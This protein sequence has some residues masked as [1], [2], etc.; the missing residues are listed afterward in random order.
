MLIFDRCCLYYLD[1]SCKLIFERRLNTVTEVDRSDSRPRHV[2]FGYFNKDDYLDIA[3]ANSESDNIGIFL[4]YGNGSFADQLTYSTGFQTRPY[5]VSIG[6]FNND[7]HVDLV[8]ANYGTNSIGVLFGYSDGTFATPILTKIG[9]SRPQSL[10]V[11]DINHDNRMDIVVVSNGTLDIMVLLGFNNGSFRIGSIY[12]MGYD[13]FPYAIASAD[14]NKDN[15]MDIAVINY[16]IDNLVILL[17]D[18]YG[19]WTRYE[20]STGIG[21]QPSSLVLG[22]VNN[23]DILDIVVAN[24]GRE[25]IGIF[26]GYQNGTFRDSI[27]HP[28]GKSSRPWFI[29]LGDFENDF[30][31]DIAVIDILNNHLIIFKGNGNESFSIELKHNTGLNSNPYSIA[32]DDFHP[33]NKSDIVIS[34]YENNN[35]LLL[36]LYQI[37]PIAI[38]RFYSTGDDSLPFY[39]VVDDFNN[40]QQLDIIVSDNAGKRLGMFLGF[41]NGT[42]SQFQTVM[43][44]EEMSPLFIISADLNNDHQ[45]DIIMTIDDYGVIGVVLG[46]NDGSFTFSDWYLTPKYSIT[47]GIT[48]ADVNNDQNI[49]II[50]SHMWSGYIGIFIGYGNGSLSQVNEYSTGPESYPSSLVAVD[51]NNDHFVDLAVIS[52]GEYR[53]SIHLGFGNGSFI[54]SSIISTGEHDP[55]QITA[56]DL[57]NDDQFDLVFISSLGITILFGYGN[58]T[59]SNLQTYHTN[60]DSQPRSLIINDFNQDNRLDI[61]VSIIGDIKLGIFLGYGDGR[62]TQMQSMSTEGDGFSRSIVS[63]DFNNDKQ[64]D[65]VVLGIQP[66]GILVYLTDLIALFEKEKYYL[67]GSIAHPYSITSGYFN[68]DTQL[69]IV[70]MDSE[71]ANGDVFVQSNNGR[72]IRKTSFST[73]FNSNPRSV[74]CADFNKDNRLDIATA[75]YRNSSIT[76]FTGLGDGTFNELH[77]Y[78]T[79]V[80]S[81]PSSAS[82]GDLNDDSWVDMIVTNQEKDNIGV[83]LTFNYRTFFSF[84]IQFES[85][86]FP[87]SMATADLNNDSHMDIVVSIWDPESIIIYFGDGKG[88]FMKAITL[89]ADQYSNSIAV[90]DFNGDNYLDIAV[91]SWSEFGLSIFL[92]HGNGT[93]AE[94]IIYFI[95]TSLSIALVS[96]DLNNDTFLDLV[97][98]DQY[99][100]RIGV[101]LGYGNGSFTQIK[102]YFMSNGSVSTSMVIEDLNGDNIRDIVIAN[103]DRHCLEILL[104]YGNGSFTDATCFSTGRYSGPCSIALGDFN[105]DHFIDIAVANQQAHNIQIFLGYG[106]GS[107]SKVRTYS[108]GLQSILRSITVGD[109]NNDS[110]LDLIFTDDENE[111]SFIGIL[112]GND[113]ELFLV[114]KMYPIGLNTRPVFILINDLNH[115]HQLDIL[116]LNGRTETIRVMLNDQSESFGSVM[117]FS[118]GD[119]SQPISSA[120][121]HLDDDHQIDIAVANYGTSNI[122]IFFGYEKG[123]FRRE[124]T[125]ST[126]TDSYPTSIALVDFNHDNHTDIVVTNRGTDNICILQGYSN[127][128]FTLFRTYSTGKGSSPSFVAIA[129]LNKDS[130]VDLVIANW[131]IN[132]F[133]IFFGLDY[134]NFSSPIF[135]PLGYNARPASI[136]IGHFNNDD[137][138]D[139]ALANYGSH[140]MQIFFQTY[141]CH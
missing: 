114:P 33:D 107:F 49:D 10:A 108:T 31:V 23:D 120:L 26:Y 45:S 41:G 140:E 99:D 103:R 51:L 55:I 17:S 131:G 125:Y 94:R 3:V 9:S 115:D 95:N 76:V 66:N 116:V 139:I 6:H 129:D 90:G 84:D 110:I 113:Q 1:K 59:F 81:F 24:S 86:S 127:G 78:S 5:W 57:N 119:H 121:A 87:Y 67:T 92:N 138:L 53:I 85:F 117:T 123:D 25:N 52:R 22:D 126:G 101:L 72:F 83:F 133:L 54:Q 62:F 105:R 69:D 15:W 74:V 111:D 35:I 141:S 47:T 32:I 60:E 21:S 91:S 2:A 8:V 11:A 136:T 50:T 65:L 34:N 130:Y 104:G 40:D 124:E 39:I 77:R 19:N 98:V 63:G 71:S 48:T 137:L 134:E 68:N 80:E 73:G 16:G 38:P 30:L 93:F 44:M 58:G 100:G 106:N 29:S 88:S 109:V 79:G 82:V 36:S 4:G 102:I 43:S 12:H 13:S 135:Y 128:N 42:F 75:N 37:Y 64:I 96:K 14:L 118:T 56:V 20:Y 122:R 61:V 70:L 112:Y 28:T 27:Q 46:E 7:Q 18:E 89:A 97:L 132:N